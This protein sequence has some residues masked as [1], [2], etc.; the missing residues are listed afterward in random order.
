MPENGTLARAR[1]KTP[2]SAA[3]AGILFSLVMFVIFWL[4]R[5]SIPADPLESASTFPKRAADRAGVKPETT[6]MGSLHSS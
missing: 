4:L 6:L 2:K 3:I 1:L 5:Q